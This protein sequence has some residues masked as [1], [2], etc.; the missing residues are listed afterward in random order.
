VE[1]P[2][3]RDQNDAA[4][5]IFTQQWALYRRFVDADSESHRAFF[6]ILHDLV[7]ARTQGFSFLDLASG[8]AFCSVD[9]LAGTAI[10]DYT[11]VDLSEQALELAAKNAV[12]LGCPFRVIAADFQDFL[13]VPQRTWDVILIGFSLHHLVGED[14][15][16]FAR[17][18]RPAVA[19]KGEWIFFEPILS[20]GE[21]R[22]SYLERWKG[23][24]DRHWTGFSMDEKALIWGHVSECD[25]P[26]SPERFE[27]IAR[28][29]G[30]SACEHLSTDPY[31]FYCAFRA[32]A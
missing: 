15:L 5:A 24:L 27:E 23:C 10:A 17:K 25:Y 19:A 6:G 22:A 9:A 26:E 2:A 29:A 13:E 3:P 21:A 11:A 7:V 32:S 20:G 4:R 8:D 14:K 18:L 30:F 16:T 1:S 28:R 12:S 31:G